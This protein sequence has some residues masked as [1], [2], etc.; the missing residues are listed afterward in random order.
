MNT[1]VNVKKRPIRVSNRALFLIFLCL[2]ALA[3]LGT[4][5]SYARTDTSIVSIYQNDVLLRRIDLSTIQSSELVP[6]G[7]GNVVLVEPGRICM[8]SATCADQRCVR[9]GFLRGNL[10]I[11]CLPNGVLIRYEAPT[12]NPYDAISGR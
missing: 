12:D 11:V 6:A 1:S 7:D 8:H 5:L 4:Y 10:P 3:A 9:Q 2:V